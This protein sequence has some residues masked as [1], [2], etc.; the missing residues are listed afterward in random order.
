MEEKKDPTP[1]KDDDF[2]PLNK[3][4]IETKAKE[5]IK[6]VAVLFG[7]GSIGQAIIRRIGVGKHIVLADLSLEHAEQTAKL[8]ENA[9]FECSTIKADLGS[10][11]PAKAQPSCLALPFREPSHRRIRKLLNKVSKLGWKS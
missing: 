7:T 10:K 4:E 6:E 8:L 1:K 9:G 5:R 3:E 11:K 2:K